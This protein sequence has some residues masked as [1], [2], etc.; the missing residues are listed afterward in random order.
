LRTI[1]SKIANELIVK[2]TGIRLR[3]NGS[4]LKGFKRFVIK[5]LHMYGEMHRYFAA[6]CGLFTD[7]ITEIE[8]KYKDRIYGKSAYGSLSRTFKVFFDLFSLKFLVS[9][10]KKPYNLMPGRLFGSVGVGTFTVGFLIGLYLTYIKLFLGESIGNRP[11]LTVS[12]L[13]IILG[14]Q[15]FMTG[16]LGELLMRIY[17]DT[18]DKEVYTV[19]EEINFD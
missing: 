3:D 19:K 7:R 8:V 2:V 14:V 13:F 16:L 4:G 11:L 5:N 6:Y 15:L 17:F 9:M 1:P 10:S 12:V 18:G